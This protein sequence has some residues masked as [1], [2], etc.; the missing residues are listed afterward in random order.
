MAMGVFSKESLDRLRTRVDLIELLSSY[1]ELKPSGSTYKACCPFHEEK[2]PSFHVKRGDSHYHCFG[3]NAHGDAIAFLMNHLGVS[4]V[5]AVEM[6]SDR[7]G[8]QMDVLENREKGTDRRALKDANLAAADFYQAM[9][10]HTDE[11]HFALNYLYK[12]GMDLEFIKHFKVGY[13][14]KNGP[15]FLQFMKERGSWPKILEEAGLVKNGRPFFFGRVMFPITEASGSIIGF[16]GRKL[17]STGDG[18]KYINTPETPIFKKSRVL[19]GLSESR[20]RITKEKQVLIVEGQIDALRLIQEGFDFT[21]AGQG[22]AFGVDHTAELMKLGVTHA[23]LGFDGDAAGRSAAV[24]V[25]NMFQKSGA[26]VS[27]LAMPEGG[28]P[29]TVLQEHG[30]PGMKELID[31]GID[32]LSFLVSELAKIHD[33]HSP[34]GKNLIVTHVKDMVKEWDHPLIVH[35]SLRRLAHLVNVPEK[36]IGIEQEKQENVFI[37]KTGTI[38]DMHIDPDRILETDLLRWLYLKPEFGTLIKKN[39]QLNHFRVS[40][41]RRLYKKYLEN[42]EAFF[43]SPLKIDNP[44]E[45]LCLSEILSRQVNLD[46]ADEGVETTILKLLERKWMMEREAIKMQIHS[47]QLDDD[48]VF[49]LAKDFDRLKNETP[50][51]LR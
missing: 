42:E 45:K 15:L 46:R 23:I 48:E 44:E 37:K 11:G 3:C 9:L 31:H 51:L 19:F 8:V 24:K 4:F 13:A 16:S 18:P 33:I 20:R 5:E 40:V 30:T 25:G 50:H 43:D 10:L 27:V 28:D 17:V 7:F 14:P 1:I 36:L 21:V 6:L 47:G 26:E 29:D 49:K 12:R 34:T 39:L 38:S 22:T 35:E 32:Y 41:C 2:T